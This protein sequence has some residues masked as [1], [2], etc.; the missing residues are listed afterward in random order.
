MSTFT[1]AVE[2]FKKSAEAWLTDADLPAV[3]AL[4]KAAEQLDKEI[5][6][7]LLSQFGLT[8]RSL[9]KRQPADL[10]EEEDPLDDLIPDH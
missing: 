2:A 5:N 10:T 1:Q 6:P 3:I 7:A 4:E 8:Y 9:L